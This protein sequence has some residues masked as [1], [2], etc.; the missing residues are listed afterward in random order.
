MRVTS[1]RRLARRLSSCFTLLFLDACLTCGVSCGGSAEALLAYQSRALS[2]TIAYERG[3]VSYEAAVTLAA[4]GEGRDATL[5]YLAPESLA[6]MTYARTGG[7]ITV[8]RGS[9]TSTASG[10]ALLPLS[11][12]AIP[13]EAKVTGIERTEGGRVATLLAGNAVYTLAFADG[14]EIPV[15]LSRAEDGAEYLALTV[16]EALSQ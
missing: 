10:D 9:I 6:G 1:E 3:G 5:T 15:S 4:G 16:K 7:E 12:F 8:T 13:V 11:L 2:L 14:Q